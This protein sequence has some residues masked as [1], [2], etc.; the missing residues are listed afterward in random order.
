MMLDVGTK[1]YQNKELL[2]RSVES[3]GLCPTLWKGGATEA[4]KNKLYS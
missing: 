3:V 1:V 4:S 2:T